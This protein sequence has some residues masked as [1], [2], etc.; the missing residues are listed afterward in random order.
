MHFPPRPG[1]ETMAATAKFSWDRPLII[2]VLKDIINRNRENRS[3]PQAR[4]AWEQQKFQLLVGHCR[5]R[6]RRGVL[7][8]VPEV[9][10][11]CGR[12]GCQVRPQQRCCRRRSRLHLLSSFVFPRCRSASAGPSL[13]LAAAGASSAGPARRKRSLSRDASTQETAPLLHAKLGPSARGRIP[14]R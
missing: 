2:D 4:Q 1:I 9:A 8:F 11:H 14:F 13:P 7:T 5:S 12:T 6:G 3:R 10:R